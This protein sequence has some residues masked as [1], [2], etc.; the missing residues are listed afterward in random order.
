MNSA[1]LIK[2]LASDARHV[3]SPF[4]SECYY[5]VVDDIADSGDVAIVLDNGMLVDAQISLSC[6]VSPMLKD[7]VLVSLGASP[8]NENFV[9]SILSRERIEEIN[10]KCAGAKTLNIE[11]EN[12]NLRGK[13]KLGLQSQIDIELLSL[14][15]ISVNAKNLMTRVTQ[16]LVQIAEYHM[17]QATH[18]AIQ[19]KQVLRAHG[20]HHLLS[21][22]EDMKIDAERINMG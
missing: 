17:N 8:D 14:G 1:I 9:L 12:L 18:I 2:S 5:G 16:N 22:K 13:N 15:N 4:L 6:I 3:Q 21:A 19:A 20:H 10:I 11:S 7:R